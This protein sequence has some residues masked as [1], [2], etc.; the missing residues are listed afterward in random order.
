MTATLLAG[1]AQAAEASASTAQAQTANTNQEVERIRT[2]NAVRHHSETLLLAQQRRLGQ[3]AEGAG[4]RIDELT[5]QAA[6]LQEA[7]LNKDARIQAGAREDS[8]LR[9]L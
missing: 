6:L 1:R 8:S 3:H 7:V 4:H 9:Q 2:E 5:S